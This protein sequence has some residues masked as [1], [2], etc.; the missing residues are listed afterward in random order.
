MSC[1][2]LRMADFL[3]DEAIGRFLPY[4]MVDGRRY[5]LLCLRLYLRLPSTWRLFGKQFLVIGSKPG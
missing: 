2:A 5:P 4:T 1:E 3:V